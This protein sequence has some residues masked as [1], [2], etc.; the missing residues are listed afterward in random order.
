MFIPWVD[1]CM[2]PK[3]LF[4]E[5]ARG[6]LDPWRQRLLGHLRGS[7]MRITTSSAG[8]FSSRVAQTL[9]LS[10]VIATAAC[11]EATGPEEIAPAEPS[12]RAAVSQEAKDELASLSDNMDDFTGWSLVA[13]PDGKGKTNIVGVLNGLKGHLKAGKLAMCQQ[14]VTDARSWF[15]SLSE[16]EQ[17]EVGAIG[18]ALDLIQAGLDKAAQ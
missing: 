16:Q 18:V 17:T 10:G 12:L 3:I 15:A 2:F 5:Y 7:A 8:S 1:K 13:L 6:R 4:A 9:V 14:D 11:Q